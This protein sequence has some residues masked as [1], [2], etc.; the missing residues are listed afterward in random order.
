MLV[1]SEERDVL[2]EVHRPALQA[3]FV[4]VPFL[5]LAGL[6]VCS[7]T[8]E[9]STRILGGFPACCWDNGTLASKH[10]RGYRIDQVALGEGTSLEL[11]LLPWRY[12]AIWIFGAEWDSVRFSNNSFARNQPVCRYSE[13]AARIDIGADEASGSHWSGCL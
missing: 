8:P 11:S 1:V 5:G 10:G 6:R 7:G 2:Q 9:G 13:S 3:T 12:G 4:F